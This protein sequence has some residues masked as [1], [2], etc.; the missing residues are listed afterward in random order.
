M[1]VFDVFYESVG[2]AW[3]GIIFIIEIINIDNYEK[4]RNVRLWFT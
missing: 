4:L 1:R 2:D 3:C